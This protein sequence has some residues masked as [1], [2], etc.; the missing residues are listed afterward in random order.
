MST[1]TER[2]LH[3]LCAL[4][5]LLGGEA[6][7]DSYHVMTGSCSL[8][9]KDIEKCAPTGIQDAFGKG[10]IFHHAADVQI[11]DGNGLIVF[12]IG[13]GGFEM[14]VATLPID[15]EM[16][17]CRILGG[18]AAA[19]TPLLRLEIVRCLRLKVLCDA[20]VGIAMGTG[21]DVA[22]ESAGVTLVKGDLGGLVR[23]IELS[24]ATMSNI[25]LN[26]AFAFVYNGIGIPVAAGALYPF[27]GLLLNPMLASAA[28]ALSSVSVIANSLRLRS[29]IKSFPA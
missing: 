14:M 5:A 20:R 1:H 24:R 17:L 9:F 13:P 2:L 19:M 12:S 11:L 10:M 4:V 25:R 26:L 16:G 22:M 8:V 27:F 7:V 15:V 21:A 29:A 28:M 3:N 23:A 6:R 18:L